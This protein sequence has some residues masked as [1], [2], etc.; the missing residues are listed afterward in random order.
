MAEQEGAT[1]GGT[2]FFAHLDELVASAE[3][4][5]DR[6]KGSRHPRVPE[7]IYPVRYGYLEGTTGGDGDGVDVFVGDASDAGVVGVFLTADLLKRDV[8]VKILL[9]C[10]PQEIEQVHHLLNDV[11]E[12]GGLLVPRR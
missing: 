3:L 7:A 5:V 1:G 6:P 8:E 10:S 2:G 12:I 11:L 9:D 4:V